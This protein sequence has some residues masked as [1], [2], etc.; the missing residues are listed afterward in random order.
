MWLGLLI[1]S[2]EWLMQLMIYIIHEKI[3]NLSLSEGSEIAEG[4]RDL[5]CIS[6]P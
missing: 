6:N 3:L 1:Q 5:G 4:L 2:E